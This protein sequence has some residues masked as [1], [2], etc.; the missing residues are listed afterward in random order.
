MTTFNFKVRATDDKGAFADRDFSI[1]VRNTVVN[2]FVATTTQG[3]ILTSIDGD[4]WTYNYN[5][6]PS[7][8]TFGDVIYGN[9]FWLITMD[10]TRY[11][12]SVDA[13]NWRVCN[14]PTGYSLTA[15]P[16]WFGFTPRWS[17][18]DGKVVITIDKDANTR[19]LIST[20]DGLNWTTH[21]SA[22][23]S[24]TNAGYRLQYLKP[25]FIDNKWWFPVAGWSGWPDTGYLAVTL[26]ADFSNT[27]GKGTIARPSSFDGT[28]T[29]AVY[30]FGGL[31][32]VAGRSDSYYISNNGGAV[33]SKHLI[34][35]TPALRPSYSM[36]SIIYGNGRLVAFPELT[37]A[38]GVT[39]YN[40]IF[41]SVDAKTWTK[42][43]AP[44]AIYPSDADLTHPLI[45]YWYGSGTSYGKMMGTFYNGVYLF[46]NRYYQGGDS[47]RSG[48]LKSNDGLTWTNKVIPAFDPGRPDVVDPAIVGAIGFTGLASMGQNV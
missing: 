17:K 45:S 25:T 1:D 47:G 39:G 33:W 4:T 23:F 35:H 29:T 28:G 19:T 40:K 14:F 38:A 34:P 15:D 12:Y 9:G 44:H 6:L 3:H 42:I 30:N 21:S 8:W 11:L 26:S 7:S 37:N 24:T 41:T 46:A 18:G 20:T 27:N 22:L 36:S 10:Q 32:I 2:R 5:Q 43:E 16:G 48:I 31:I 13:V